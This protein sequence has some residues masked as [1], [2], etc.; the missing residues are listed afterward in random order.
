MMLAEADIAI[1]SQVPATIAS[2]LECLLFILGGIYLAVSLFRL[3]AGRP[4]QPPNEQLDRAMSELAKTV[5]DHIATNRHEHENI[6]SKIGGVE[7]GAQA[8]LEAAIQS[9]NVSREKLHNRINVCAEAMGTLR[10][11]IDSLTALIKKI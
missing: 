1:A 3:L 10:G 5:H 6:H 2:W 7:R 9:G 8:K 11:A 4:A